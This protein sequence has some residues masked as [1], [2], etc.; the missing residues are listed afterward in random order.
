[1]RGELGGRFTKVGDVFYDYAKIY[2]SL[3]GYDYILIQNQAPRL[4]DLSPLKNVFEEI[5][6]SKFGSDMLEYLKY[7]TASLFFSLI[8]L[9]DNEKCE[10]FYNCIFDLIGE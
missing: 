8:P 4:T 10:K 5:F 6:M 2:Q 7:L 3:V 9:H 1:M